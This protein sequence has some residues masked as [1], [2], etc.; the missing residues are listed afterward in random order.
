MI[1]LITPTG[2]RQQQI[3]LCAR[4]MKAQTY[5]G[6]VT[7]LIIDDAYPQTT[8]GIIPGFREGW[9]IVKQFP[10]P[11]WGLGQNTQRRNMDYAMEFLQVNYDMNNIEAIFIIED[12]DYYKPVYLD[13][14]MARLGG[15]WAIG[16]TRTVYYN[17]VNRTFFINPNMAHASLFQTAFTKEAIPYMKQSHAHHF[18]D[19]QFWKIC[20]NKYLFPGQKFSIGIKGM[21]GR[22]GI[23]AGHKVNFHMTPDP[24]M[25]YLRNTIGGDANTYAKYFNAQMAQLHNRPDILSGRRKRG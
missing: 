22:A 24:N 1:V 19:A 16:E 2:A 14:M 23:G 6:K 18:I 13:E 5:T 8:K 4:W 7:W 9:D 11:P 20:Q 17:V 12:D 25:N 10:T 3:N 15:Y 21:A